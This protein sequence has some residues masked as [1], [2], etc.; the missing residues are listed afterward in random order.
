M[1]AKKIL[2]L[3][4]VLAL[5]LAIFALPAA[6]ETHDHD[7]CADCAAESVIMRRPPAVMCPYCAIRCNYN[8][9]TKIHTC[10]ECGWHT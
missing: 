2:S 10:P 6:A 5:A 3:L 1:Q 4:L 8:A 9:A 7:G